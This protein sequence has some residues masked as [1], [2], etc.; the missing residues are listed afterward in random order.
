M[1]L[2]YLL[3]YYGELTMANI[4][5]VVKV[6]NF[7]SLLRVDSAKKKADKYLLMENE[8]TAMIDVILNNRN[9]I[10]DKKVLLP[11]VDKP[12]LKIYFGSDYG[13]CSNYNSL[14]MDHIKQDANCEKVIFGKKISKVRNHV[15]LQTTREA[16]EKD[17]SILTTI[18]QNAVMNREYSEIVVI[19]NRYNSVSDITLDEKCI[20][21]VNFEH[22]DKVSYNEDFLYEGDINRILSNL[23][24][25][26][27]EYQIKV[28]H[29]NTAAAEN[30]LRQNTTRDS[31]RRI[32]EREEVM[33]RE[34]RKAKKSKEFGKI[35]ESFS[36][37]RAQGR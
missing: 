15:V 2:K 22:D 18:V 32:D 14:I 1:D 31:L 30:I 12:K 4:K 9:F 11:N 20:Y 13:F 35:I 21:P 23:I 7:H 28:C 19:Y 8:I 26:Y 24:S 5:N 37:Q 36:K 34:T 27:L 25:L 6:M 16:F 3:R 33:I 10:L 17:A 29:V